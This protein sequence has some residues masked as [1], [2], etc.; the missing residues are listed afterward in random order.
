M[1]IFYFLTKYVL[2]EN[3][4]IKEEIAQNKQ[5]LL[6]LPRFQLYSIIVLSFEESFQTISCMFLKSSAAE[7]LY[8]GK[9]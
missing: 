5:F 2:F 8:V 7:L 4:A 6:L 9:G 3:M 1:K